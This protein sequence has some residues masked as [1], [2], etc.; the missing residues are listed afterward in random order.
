M[1]RMHSYAALLNPGLALSP[2]RDVSIFPDQYDVPDAHKHLY[3]SPEWT[4]RTWQVLQS[5]LSK[6]FSF[7]LPVSRASEILA[8][9]QE[10]QREDF[11]DDVYICLSSPE[12][13]PPTPVGIESEDES[14]VHKSMNVETVVD[15][16]LT[17]AGAQGDLIAVPQ[18]ISHD[19]IAECVSKD[20]EISDLTVLIKKDMSGKHL[21]NLPTSDELPAELIVS[22]T[23]AKRTVTDESLV[24]I[25]TATKGNEFELSDCS[26]AKGVNSL[27]NEALS[28]INGDCTGVPKLR[29]KRRRKRCRGHYRN[30]KKASK[31]VIETPS[32]QTVEIPVENDTSNSQKDDL[33]KQSSGHSM[34]SSPSSIPWRKLRRRKRIFC[35]LPSRNKKLRSAAIG[36]LSD[37]E[38][39]ISMEFQV[40]PLRKKTERWD[41][42]PV[43]SECGRILVPHGSSDFADQIKSLKHELSKKSA[44]DEQCPEQMLVDASKSAFETSVNGHDTAE[45]EQDSSIAPVTTV[46]KTEF[47]TLMDGMNHVHN[48]VNIPE[49]CFLRKSDHNKG[50]QTL[51]LKSSKDSSKSDGTDTAPLE[52]PNENH[53]DS[54]SPA[55]CASKGEFLLSKLKSVLLRGKRKREYEGVKDPESCVKKGKGDSG[56]LKTNNAVKSIQSTNEGVKEGSGMLSLDPAFAHALGLTPKKKPD[57]TQKTEGP[58]A[59]PK[60]DSSETREDTIL[61]KRAQV[62][63]A[64]PLN[65]TRSRI[66]TLK[67]R[68]GIPT[69]YIKKKWWLHFQSPACFATEKL[70]CKEYTRD[71]SVRK[72]VK[73]KMNNACSSTDA[74]NLLADLALSASN[75]QVPPQPDPSLER[76]PETGL[77]K[78]DLTKD[79]TS[80]EQESFL[81]TLLRK[82]AAKPIQPLKSP[83][84]CHLVGGTELI[85]LISKEHA[86]SLPPSSFLLLGLPGTPFQVSPLSGSTRLLHH[87]QHLYGNGF[88]ALQ[89]SLCQEDRGEHNNRTP[90]YLIKH[91]VHRQKFKHSRTFVNKDD[92]ILI[93]RHW[94]DN[95][96]FNLDSKFTSDPKDRTIIRALHGPWDFSI[97]DTSE[98]V[99]VIVHMWIGLFYSRSTARFFQIDS[100]FKYP[101]S[102]ESDS[103]DAFTGNP[104]TPA[105]SELRANT[106]APSAIV[107]H[108]SDSVITKALDLSKKDNS[109]LDQGP[110]IWDLSLRNSNEET[111]SSAPQS[112]QVLMGLQE[113]SP[114]QLYRKLV[115]STE[116]IHKV[117]DATSINENE[118]MYTVLQSAGCQEYID[119][120]SCKVNGPQNPSQEETESV[121]IGPENLVTASGNDH[122]LCGS[123]K[124]ETG[125]KDGIENSRSTEM[126]LAQKHTGDLSKC[127]TDEEMESIKDMEEVPH[128]T[129]HG[130]I[131]SKD[132]A[133]SQMKENSY[134]VDNTEP[135]K[136]IDLC[137]DS[138][139][140]DL[141]IAYSGKCFENEDQLSGKEPK[142]VSPAQIDNVDV[143]FCTVDEDKMINDEDQLGREDGPD[144]KAGCISSVDAVGNVSDETLPVMCDS[145][146]SLKDC[147]TDCS[148]Q[149]TFD[150]QLP[151]PD[152]ESDACCE[153]SGN[154]H[155]FKDEHAASE[156]SQT[157]SEL[158]PVYSEPLVEE[159]SEL[160]CM[161]DKAA[162]LGCNESTCS[163]E[164]S[165]AAESVPKIKESAEP[166]SQHMDMAGFTSDQEKKSTE[167]QKNG[168]PTKEA[169]HHQSFT[170]V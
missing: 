69:E 122:V 55:K 16:C 57:R 126:S 93:T 99:Q 85:E 125:P 66:K 96:D 59:Q 42:K 54:L 92:S 31:A 107:R 83:P 4:P 68:Q 89:P 25:S 153:L 80:A 166:E 157:V 71:N 141:N 91:M 159:N 19:W 110:L 60:K 163:L 109:V 77:K 75:G 58:D 87:H 133:N 127:V 154:G 136:V 103:P 63:A 41:L 5:Y 137:D 84:P 144:E 27:N 101:C 147:I 130:E 35:K 117:D 1:Q 170:S 48:V 143:D 121:P 43:V 95:Y 30:Q 105:Q 33:T 40:C 7:Q 21:L 45:M 18:S 65:I 44:K 3:T 106:A 88:Q 13:V 164:G 97:Q 23:S 11:D 56:L 26:A 128:T 50:S 167:G 37:P 8:A 32:L 79:V 64:T 134:Q 169:L 142:E 123:K 112:T 6:P 22:I 129:E 34:L 113:A 14:T 146:E 118:K 124:E 151:Q 46:E 155:A 162:L 161:A 78:C 156:K 36:A 72:T 149:S 131:E 17:S 145:Y 15:S 115:L 10:G 73:E 62:I 135:P 158:Q 74:L 114:F 98:E 70:K 2:S 152:S 138:T 52:A 116:S 139:K 168:D 104:S 9:G 148:P 86:Y 28:V 82:P 38:S 119:V 81:H 39:A 140:D 12:E 67:K 108:T 94:K 90:E 51:N 150:D 100:N 53:T 24:G 102:E 111:H 76:K 120:R 20:N 160:D 29:K 47:K 61:E 132:E 165:C 49:D